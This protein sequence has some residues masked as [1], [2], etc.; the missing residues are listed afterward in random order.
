MSLRGPTEA[1]SVELCRSPKHDRNNQSG[2]GR[3]QA[4]LPLMPPKR[5]IQKPVKP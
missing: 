4:P 5:L 3:P 2:K 1:G